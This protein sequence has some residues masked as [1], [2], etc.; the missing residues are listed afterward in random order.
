MDELPV[1][2]EG[3]DISNLGAEHTVASMVVFEGGAPKK[4]D[5]RTLQDPRGRAAAPTTSPRWRRC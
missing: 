1:R 2:I 5:Y 4:S 3:Y